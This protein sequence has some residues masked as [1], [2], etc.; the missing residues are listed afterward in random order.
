M[1]MGR[2]GEKCTL[3]TEEEE[4]EEGVGG[5]RLTVIRIG[6]CG[7]ETIPVA[8]WSKAAARLQGLRIRISKRA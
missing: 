3:G 8:A 5:D 2:Y 6:T 7:T 1:E 4:E